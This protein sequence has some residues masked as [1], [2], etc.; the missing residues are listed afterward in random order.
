ML[1]RQNTS[2]KKISSSYPSICIAKQWWKLHKCTDDIGPKNILLKPNYTSQTIYIL[3]FGIF[4]ATP[5]HHIYTHGPRTANSFKEVSIVHR[6]SLLPLLSLSPLTVWSLVM[7]AAFL[8]GLQDFSVSLALASGLGGL[9][10]K[11]FGPGLD[12]ICILLK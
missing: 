3:L 12:N 10:T 1:L 5:L 2:K 4:A 11:G 8:G 7:R 9:E 6:V